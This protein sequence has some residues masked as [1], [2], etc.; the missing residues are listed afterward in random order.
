[1]SLRDFWEFLWDEGMVIS[2]SWFLFLQNSYFF[3]V[4]HRAF[5]SFLPWCWLHNGTHSFSL[6]ATQKKPCTKTN[7]VGDFIKGSK[8]WKEFI[9]QQCKLLRNAHWSFL[10]LKASRPLYH[11]TWSVFSS[12]FSMFSLS[13]KAPHWSIF[14]SLFY[15]EHFS[16][17]SS[18]ACLCWKRGN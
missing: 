3:T 16:S 4:G 6:T 15:T 8:R 7:F 17:L 18:C 12:F 10:F 13:G 1:M 2:G 14:L 5:H 9:M 11:Y